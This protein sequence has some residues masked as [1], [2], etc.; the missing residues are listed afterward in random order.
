[1][2]QIKLSD[3]TMK[4]ISE[5]FSLSF[6]EK[7]EFSKLL[8]KLG[9]DVIELEGIKNVRTD[10]LLIKSIAGVISDSSVAVPVELNDASVECAWC[11]LK[12]AKHPRLQVAAPTS[13]VQIEYLFH[14]KP[15]AMIEAIRK[16]VEKCASYTADVEFIATDATRSDQ[17]Y[18]T[19]AVK[20]AIDAGAAC[21]RAGLYSLYHT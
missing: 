17:D 9:V 14:K 19:L 6:K 5:D 21:H 10:S 20:T 16:T 11:A 3:V 1:M 4:Q 18:L 8:D 15:D 7:I 2:K 13:S 12:S